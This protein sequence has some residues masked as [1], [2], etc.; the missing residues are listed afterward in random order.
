MAAGGSREQDPQLPE[1][2]SMLAVTPA[3]AAAVTAILQ[4]PELPDGAGLRLESGID[5]A[6]ENGVGIAIVTEPERDD[7]HVSAAPDNVFVAH[8]L[9]DVVDD[10][11]LDAEIDGQNVAFTIR[12]QS[13]NGQLG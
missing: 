6:G 12:P 4:N 9:V 11:V 2:A 5:A 1:G 8:E 3:A 7:E 10:H 13:L